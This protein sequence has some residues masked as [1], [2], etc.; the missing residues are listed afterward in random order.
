MPTIS[1]YV[2]VDV[3]L[4]DFDTDELLDEL[5]D[6]GYTMTELGNLDLEE[7]LLKVFDLWNRS[8]R[9]EDR[10]ESMVLLERIY[11]SLR[12]IALFVK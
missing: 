11:P 1:A 2:D 6:R 9:Y 12:N 7:E 3:D 5:N 10:Y 4:K 8:N